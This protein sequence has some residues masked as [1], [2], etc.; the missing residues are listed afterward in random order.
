MQCDPGT[1]NPVIARCQMF[2]RRNDS[3]SLAGAKS[4]FEGSSVVNQVACKHTCVK[5]CVILVDDDEGN[6][7]FE[8]VESDDAADHDDETRIRGYGRYDDAP[9]LE[10]EALFLVRSRSRFGR[11]VR[12]NGRFIQ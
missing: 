9:R 6:D 1:E 12:F 2:L 10:A 4:Y 8:S 11:T 5:C 7:E 3:Y